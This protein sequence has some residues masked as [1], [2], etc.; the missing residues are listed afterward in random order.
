MFTCRRVFIR[1]CRTIP[2][3]AGGC[4][5]PKEGSSAPSVVYKRCLPDL[6][7]TDPVAQRIVPYTKI[8]QDRLPRFSAAVLCGRRSPGRND[9]PSLFASALL[10]TRK[11][12]RKA[13]LKSGYDEVSLTSLSTTDTSV[14]LHSCRALICVNGVRISIPS[15]V[16]TR[17][18]RRWREAVSTSRM[19]DQTFAPEAGSSA[20]VTS[21]TKMLP[22]MI[23]SPR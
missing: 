14:R 3:H 2:Q 9:A 15:H 12:A 6:S 10:S 7:V 22:R 20:C 4:S 19:A 21:S 8:V 11:Q 18:A 16:W 5:V 1:L 13:F 17:L 23:L